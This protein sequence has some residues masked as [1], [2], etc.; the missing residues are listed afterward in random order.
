MNTNDIE[1]DIIIPVFNEQDNITKVLDVLKNKIHSKFRILICYD[2]DEDNT[3]PAI[4]SHNTQD[5]NIEFVKNK[6]RGAHSAIVTGFEYSTAPYLL[7]YPADDDFNAHIIDDLLNKAKTGFDIVCPSRLM[8]GGKMVGAPLLKSLLLRTANFI[9][10]HIARIGVHDSSNG[11]RLF[12]KRIINEIKIESTKGF[13]YSL[14]LLVKAKRFNYKITEIPAVWYEREFGQSRFQVIKWVP[15]YSRWF[16][17]AFVTNILFFIPKNLMHLNNNIN[18]NKKVNFGII[19]TNFGATVHA[20]AIINSKKSNL[21]GITGSNYNKT[22]IIADNLNII[23]YKSYQEL[24]NDG[25]IDA[26]TI[27]TPP[28]IGYKIAIE[29]LKKNK[30][31]FLEK[32]MAN[33]FTNAKKLFDIAH[34]FNAINVID[35]QFPEIN[36]FVEAKKLLDDKIIGSLNNIVVNFHVETRANK[37][38]NIGENSELFKNWKLNSQS[39]G[40]TLHNFA[41]HV[42]YYLEWFVGTIINININTYNKDTLVVISGDLENNA[43]FSIN[44]STNST[45]GSGHKIEFYGKNGCIVLDN[46]ANDYMAGFILKYR[47][48]DN[49]WIV[50]NK[51]NTDFATDGR[52]PPVARLIEKFTDNILNKKNTFGFCP[53]FTAGLRVQKLLESK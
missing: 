22:C 13:T 32:P 51:P 20:P 45:N 53:D 5:L 50:K 16:I 26:V 7:V 40:G 43:A 49:N 30:A 11:F 41:S 33:N 3:L 24:L 15:A 2:F 1:L 18:T 38:I 47:T 34:Q 44:I 48:R 27:A 6:T 52:I 17:Y 39:G 31:V 8:P 12:S 9:L 36:E 37:A 25:N 4:K 14:E 10:Y 28:D 19:G 29:A 42:L 23:A 35:F 21:I 46:Q